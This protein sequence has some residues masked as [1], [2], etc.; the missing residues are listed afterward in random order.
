M[1]RSFSLRRMVIVSLAVLLAMIFVL[2]GALLNLSTMRTVSALNGGTS[3]ASLRAAYDVG[4]MPYYI[5]SVQ[6]SWT[7]PNITCPTTSAVAFYEVAMDVIQTSSFGEE[8]G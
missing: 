5:L 7:V 4:S 6:G 2:P 3:S 1:P 8:N